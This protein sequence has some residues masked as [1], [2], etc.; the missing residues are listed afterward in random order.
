MKTKKYNKKLILK[1]IIGS[2]REGRFSE[3]VAKWVFNEIKSDPEII[4]EILDLR[5]YPM[6]FFNSAIY[7]SLA[8]KKYDNPV[9]QEWSNKIDEADGFLII[10][11]E[12]NAGYP[13][14]LKNA[15][16]VIYPEWN[17]KPV[18]F[19][20]YGSVMGSRS[21]EQLKQVSLSLQMHPIKNS[22]NIPNEIFFKAMNEEEDQA[23]KTLQ[24][25]TLKKPNPVYK[26]LSELIEWA[27]ILKKG[28]YN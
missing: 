1:I 8:N 4:C 19:I 22:I 25:L 6:P 2:T 9:I 28:R 23:I 3:K 17:K 12:Y 10:S 11:P 20:S 5:D 26:C 13:A 27:K 16:D 24:T 15:L 7:P 21:I 14:V 18:G